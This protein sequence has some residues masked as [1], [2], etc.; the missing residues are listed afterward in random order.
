[1]RIAFH[2]RWLL[3][4]TEGKPVLS[5]HKIGRSNQRPER[6]RFLGSRERK[7][8]AAYGTPRESGQTIKRKHRADPCPQEVLNYASELAGDSWLGDCVAVTDNR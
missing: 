5:H 1:M 7:E 8:S 2:H 3:E 4:T 6:I